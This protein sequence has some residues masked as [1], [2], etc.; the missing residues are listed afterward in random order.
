MQAQRTHSTHTYDNVIT[1]EHSTHSDTDIVG[2]YTVQVAPSLS[3]TQHVYNG[4]TCAVS[5]DRVRM[6]S[7]IE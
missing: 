7:R 5:L 1:V 2:S 4:D 6:I 3:F